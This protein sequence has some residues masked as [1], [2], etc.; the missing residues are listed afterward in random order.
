M[1]KKEYSGTESLSL[2]W[3]RIKVRQV[4]PFNTTNKLL[5]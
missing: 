4:A 5:T 2:S 3:D 1:V